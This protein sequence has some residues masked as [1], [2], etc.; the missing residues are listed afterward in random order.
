M[1]SHKLGL[2]LFCDREEA[3]TKHGTPPP[4]RL[5]ALELRVYI[6]AVAEFVLEQLDYAIEP[7]I[8]FDEEPTEDATPT[9]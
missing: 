6:V 7:G 4:S 2:E 1:N 3:C 8:I 5:M 9:R